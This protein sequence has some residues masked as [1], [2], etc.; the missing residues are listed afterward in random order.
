MRTVVDLSLLIAVDCSKPVSCWFYLGMAEYVDDCEFAPEDSESGYSS[1]S[2]GPGKE[3]AGTFTRPRT[4]KQPKPPSLLLL[5]KSC[6]SLF[7]GD[8]EGSV[9]TP[10]NREEH[11]NLPMIGSAVNSPTPIT[12]LCPSRSFP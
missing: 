5:K 10:N 8:R 2:R 3:N 6:S 11:Y 4:R 9:G 12:P 7:K 1:S